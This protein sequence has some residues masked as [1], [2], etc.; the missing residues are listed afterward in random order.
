MGKKFSSLDAVEFHSS[1]HPT[2]GTL[3]DDFK[4]PLFLQLWSNGSHRQSP[5]ESSRARDP[6]AIALSGSNGGK[7]SPLAQFAGKPS[8]FKTLL[9]FLP[10]ETTYGTGLPLSLETI[11][12]DSWGHSS[13]RHTV[14]K[15]SQIQMDPTMIT[16]RNTTMDQT[17]SLL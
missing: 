15:M 10:K 6:I 4:L 5:P 7:T 16:A 12:R 1:T 9:S 13:L 11:M 17:I 8:T 3:H 2:R 14:T